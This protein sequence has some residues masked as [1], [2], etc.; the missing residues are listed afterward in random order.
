MGPR[1]G[2]ISFRNGIH[3]GSFRESYA[4]TRLFFFFRSRWPSMLPRYLSRPPR[5]NPPPSRKATTL[6]EVLETFS[7]GDLSHDSEASMALEGIWSIR[8]LFPSFYRFLKK[9]SIKA[10]CGELAESNFSV[11]RSVPR[12]AGHVS[13]FLWMSLGM[14]LQLVGTQVIYYSNYQSQRNIIQ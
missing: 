13:P 6:K 2:S 14:V 9:S 7:I 1:Y 11:I 8:Q 12:V 5:F 3:R 10:L 4:G